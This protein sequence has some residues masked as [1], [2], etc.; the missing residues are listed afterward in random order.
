MATVLK[1]QFLDQ[2]DQETCQ[3]CKFLGLT[4]SETGAG[5]SNR[6]PSLRLCTRAGSGLRITSMREAVT[7]EEEREVK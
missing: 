1:V 2:H 3:I 6:N 5:A 7:E 4:H